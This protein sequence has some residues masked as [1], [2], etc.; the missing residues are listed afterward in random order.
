MVVDDTWFN[1]SLNMEENLQKFHT[2][3]IHRHL[4]SPWTMHIVDTEAAKRLS[5]PFIQEN[6]LIAIH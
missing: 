3:Y 6:L 2:L 1:T 5:L 4:E